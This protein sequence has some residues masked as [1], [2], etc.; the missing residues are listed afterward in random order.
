ML[1]LI[2]DTNALITSC[3]FYVGGLPVIKYIAE[4]CEIII[5]H[6]V[7]EEVVSAGGKYPNAVVAK[8]LI[9]EGKIGVRTVSILLSSSET[10]PHLSGIRI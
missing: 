7:N 10:H 8:E 3:K 5:S 4:R 9:R 6:S 2:F 1:K